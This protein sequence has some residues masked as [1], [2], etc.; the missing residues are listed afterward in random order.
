[1]RSL[2]RPYLPVLFLLVLSPAVSTQPS[3]QAVDPSLPLRVIVKLRLQAAGD[4]DQ[5]LNEFRVRHGLGAPRSVHDARTRRRNGRRVDDR[6]LTEEVRRRFP[7][8]ARRHSGSSP[9]LSNTYVFQASASSRAEL[10]ARLA[11]LSSDPDVLFAEED[12]VAR[13][14]FGPNDPYYSTAGTW[15]QTYDDLYGLKKIGAGA[16]WDSGA[17]LG[18]TVA[19]VDTGIDYTHADLANNVWIN[20]N[21]V[22]GNGIDDDANGYVDDVRGW[23]FIGTSYWQA[24]PDA[25]PADGHGHGTHVAGTIAAEGN[26]GAGIIGVAWQAKV[27]AVKGLDD[28]GSGY[29]S[30]LAGAIVYAADNGADVINASWGNRGSSQIIEDAVAYATSVGVV[31][32]AAAGNSADDARRY[33][34]RRS[35]ERHHGCGV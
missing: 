3:A 2:V 8:C 22:L 4:A 29:D 33:Y 12:K 34:P 26:N 28:G 27:M 9:D 5:R 6:Q 35:C 10:A 31:F 13:I 20:P 11:T 19:V 18:V 16:A 23:D 25:D 15:G 14:T 21:E 24:T 1:M 32:V 17:G 30:Q 7:A